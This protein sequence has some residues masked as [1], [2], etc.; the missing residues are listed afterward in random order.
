MRWRIP[1]ASGCVLEDGG[2]LGVPGLRVLVGLGLPAR[3]RD[4][5][6]VGHGLQRVVY[7]HHLQRLVRGQIPQRSCQKTW[8]KKLERDVDGT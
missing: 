7:D 5:H 6:L 3:V 8:K 1:Q 4:D 2:P